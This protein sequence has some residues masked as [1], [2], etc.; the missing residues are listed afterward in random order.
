MTSVRN[1]MLRYT[2]DLSKRWQVGH[3]RP[4]APSVTYTLSDG[5]NMAIRQRMPDIPFY[6]QY[7]WNEG[8]NHIRVSWSTYGVCPIEI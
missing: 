2:L 3:W 8:N 5:N 7:G 6:V 4:K 1:V